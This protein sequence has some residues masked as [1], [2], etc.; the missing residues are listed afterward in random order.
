MVVLRCDQILRNKF[1]FCLFVLIRRRDWGMIFMQMGIMGWLPDPVPIVQNLSQW[2]HLQDLWFWWITFQIIL[3]HHKVVWIT[4]LS[5]LIWWRLVLQQ[6][7]IA[8]Q[9]SSQLISIKYVLLT[10]RYFLHELGDNGLL[11]RCRWVTDGE[12]RELLMKPT[13]TW[14]A[15]VTALPIADHTFE[16]DIITIQLFAFSSLNFHVL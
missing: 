3:M 10:L 11:S 12:P 4:L 6:Q 13:G 8:G 14:P 15:A 16:Q 7:G 2:I 1:F 5:W 9:I